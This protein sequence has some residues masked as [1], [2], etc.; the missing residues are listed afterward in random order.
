LSGRIPFR[1]QPMLTTLVHE[2]FHLP[3]WVCAEKHGGCRVL[4]YREG[5]RVTLLSRNA[6]DR[7]P[8]VCRP[9]RSDR[10]APSCGSAPGVGPER[11]RRAEILQHQLE[12]LQGFAARRSFY[13][14]SALPALPS[15]ARLALTSGRAST[16]RSFTTSDF[17]INDAGECSDFI[18]A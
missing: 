4:A 6:R 9:G 13:R 10:C 7:T 12:T 1:V 11:G 14:V 3:G 16:A 18:A 8:V 2:P 5:K 17:T 15:R